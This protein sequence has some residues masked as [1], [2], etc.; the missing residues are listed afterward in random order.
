VGDGPS[1]TD[2]AI[3]RTS[4]TIVLELLL[5]RREQ[6]RA[7]YGTELCGWNG[8]DST[9]DLVQE[10]TDALLYATQREMEGREPYPGRLFE[11]LESALH[12]VATDAGEG[13][14]RLPHELPSVPVED[15]GVLDEDTWSEEVERTAA[16]VAEGLLG[17]GRETGGGR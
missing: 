14:D 8:R 9:A 7:R 15:A 2:A 6:G 1:V 3:E 16:A 17:P 10:L 4:S 11:V 12:R 5:A 13:L